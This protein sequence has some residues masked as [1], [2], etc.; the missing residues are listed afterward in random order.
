MDSKSHH[1]LG[2]SEMDETIS[3][4]LLK[5]LVSLFQSA[6]YLQRKMGG[7]GRTGFLFVL[8]LLSLLANLDLQHCRI[9]QLFSL[10]HVPTKA[11]DT[12]LLS[13]LSQVLTQAREEGC[14]KQ[15]HSKSNE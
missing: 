12:V 11:P 15:M 5:L 7:G 14:F 13:S 9:P 1:S 8:P 4:I 2:S 3:R 10:Y 6:S